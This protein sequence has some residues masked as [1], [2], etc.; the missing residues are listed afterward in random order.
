[1]KVKAELEI[2][3]LFLVIFWGRHFEKGIEG[4]RFGQFS[5]VEIIISRKDPT[6]NVAKFMVV[7]NVLK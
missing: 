7:L 6:K 2:P 3:I 5:I 4:F 1:M